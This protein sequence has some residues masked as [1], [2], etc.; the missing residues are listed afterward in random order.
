MSLS[1]IIRKARLVRGL[2]QRELAAR[3][4]VHHSAVGAWEIG[5]NQP[6]VAHKIALSQ[7]I[8]IRFADLLPEVGDGV[9]L[10]TD[11]TLVALVRLVERQPAARRVDALR[12]VA[13]W[14]ESE[15]TPPQRRRAS[16]RSSRK[17]RAD[18]AG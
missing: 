4:G 14:L 17:Q 15:N 18:T 5:A 16:G 13:L 2:T 10:V 9:V 3:L 12:A 1:D 8:G 11:R 6:A 7:V